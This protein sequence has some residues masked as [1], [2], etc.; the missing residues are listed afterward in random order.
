MIA[1]RHPTARSGYLLLTVL[2][3]HKRCPY[4]LRTDT[5][6]RQKQQQILRAHKTVLVDV[7]RTV[8]RWTFN[9]ALL[10]DCV[11]AAVN[12]HTDYI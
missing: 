5:P 9:G 1:L 4:A 2:V 12:E 3:H 10:N 7:R 8:T 11:A 6:T